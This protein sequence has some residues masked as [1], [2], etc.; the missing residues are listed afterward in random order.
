MGGHRHVQPV[1]LKLCPRIQGRPEPPLPTVHRYPAATAPPEGST[2]LREAQ[3]M[4]I[5]TI[6]Q[7]FDQTEETL[8]K[9][10]SAVGRDPVSLR[11]HHGD[12][13]NARQ[14]LRWEVSPQWTKPGRAPVDYRNPPNTA[15]L[16]ILHLLLATS[17]LVSAT[18]PRGRMLIL[19]ESGNNLDVP[20]LRKV[21]Q[22]LRQVADTYSL[23]MVLACQDIYTSLVSKHSTGMIQLVRPSE[24]DVLNAPP[25]ILQQ[26][27]DP[28]LARSLERYLQM[29]RPSGR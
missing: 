19:D 22:V 15:E 14:W 4:H 27:D 3:L 24:A 28:V 11:A 5:S 23:T 16:I 2:L 9:L 29:G 25:V 18:S 20:N 7:M 17:A 8:Q 10:L 21:S 12:I 1:S 6:R 13:Q 26:E